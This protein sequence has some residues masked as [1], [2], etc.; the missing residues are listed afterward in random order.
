MKANLKKEYQKELAKHCQ[1]LIDLAN[2]RLRR[3]ERA[4]LTS[5]AYRKAMEEGYFS[6]RG[7]SKDWNKLMHEYGR[8]V[9]FLNMET[10]TLAGARQYERKMENLLGGKFSEKQKN[11]VWGVF[12]RLHETN[13]VSM[14][15]IDYGKLIQYISSNVEKDMT[16]ANAEFDETSDEYQDF[17]NNQLEK[18]QKELDDIYEKLTS[19]TWLNGFNKIKW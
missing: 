4:K 11:L 13:Q 10:S 3:I 7:I 12:N 2:K 19:S 16:S 6:G 8:V 1:R 17:F 5:P 14:Q 15:M 18:A 9:A